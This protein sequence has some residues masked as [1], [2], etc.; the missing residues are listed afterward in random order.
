MGIHFYKPYTPGTRNRSVS[1]F[2]EITKNE[3]E[4]TLTSPWPKAAGRNNRGV[5]AGK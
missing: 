5:S 4:P 1:D 3:P 2:K